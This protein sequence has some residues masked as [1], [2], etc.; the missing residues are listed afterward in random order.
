MKLPCSLVF[1]IAIAISSLASQ[2]N[3]CESLNDGTNAVNPSIT[4]I[5]FSGTNA[6][7]YEIT[8]QQ[9]HTVQSIRILTENTFRPRFMALEI[10]DRDPATGF[11]S[12]RLGRGICNLEAGRGLAWQG[13]N[14]DKPVALSQ[15]TLYMLVW[16]E[17]G[18]SQPPHDP[19]G[20]MVPRLFL[21]NNGWRASGS[22]AV[23]YR[24]YCSLLDSAN[25][26]PAGNSC[27][28]SQG[29]EGTL[30]SN[31]EPLVG[32]L[33]FG[34]EGSGFDPGAAAVLLLG[35]N[36]SFNSVP[37]TGFPAGCMLHTDVVVSVTAAI[38]TGAV[39]GTSSPA[40]HVLFPLGLPNNAALSGAIFRGQLGAVDA[41]ATAVIP[42]VM[43]N[44]M[45][46]LVP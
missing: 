39:G 38:G 41:G 7:A 33:A 1:A 12:A 18:G 16:R 45:V 31:E 15:G 32:N 20:T 21:G 9:T 43:S 35:V 27:T 36:P 44:G 10:H 37:L 29:T 30:F 19:T 13:V 14:F 2:T 46:M 23:K 5:P 3:P 6:Y 34:L 40:G 22:A 42:V 11:P 26:I 8:A 17:P 25:L 4:G 28:S 24:L